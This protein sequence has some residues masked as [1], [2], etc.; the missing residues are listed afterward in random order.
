MKKPR[1]GRW[2]LVLG[3]LVIAVLLAR[4]GI[5][6]AY[7]QAVAKATPFDVG[8]ARVWEHRGH[9][10]STPPNSIVGVKAALAAGAQGVE[11]D[12]RYLPKRDRFVLA[13]DA[14]DDSAS[15]ANELT[16]DALLSAIHQ[17]NYW[18]LDAKNL[19]NL[20]PWQAGAAVARLK[21]VLER[22]T[23]SERSIVETSN[24]LYLRWV[25]QAGIKTALAVKPN[26]REHAAAVFWTN[27]YLMKWFYS[28]GPFSA[29]TMGWERYT[30]AVRQAFGPRISVNLSTFRDPKNMAPFVAMPQVQVL[31]IEGDF[32]ALPR[33]SK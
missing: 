18:W 5:N 9:I 25:K 4:W 16:L 3:V 22:H 17:G 2:A 12:I 19:R 11:I 15:T 29:I 20:W 8:C 10:G 32:F 21:L 14:I 33:C 26:D 28:W 1:L 23:A 30:P 13:H 31:L 24:P 7:Q 27:T 6:R